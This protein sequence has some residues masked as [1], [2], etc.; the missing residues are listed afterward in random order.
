MPYSK[1]RYGSRKKFNK[2]KRCVA[3]VK[4]KS[5]RKVNPYAVCR[6]SIYKKKRKK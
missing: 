4:K 6:A 1:K 2:M 3:S 5:K